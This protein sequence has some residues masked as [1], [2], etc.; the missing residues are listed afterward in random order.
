[1]DD[2]PDRA[3]RTVEELVCQSNPP[4]VNTH[5]LT[6]EDGYRPG[7][8]YSAHQL[9]EDMQH[10]QGFRP[11]DSWSTSV[12]NEGRSAWTKRMVQDDAS[13]YAHYERT[14]NGDTSHYRSGRAKLG[15]AE[16]VRGAMAGY[17]EG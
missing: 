10:P 13:E 1:M 9:R 17:R 2:S 8:P 16:F 6:E 15:G 14:Q 5:V 4:N 11:S 3:R 12:Y 7:H